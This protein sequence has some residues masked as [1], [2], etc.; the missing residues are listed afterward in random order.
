MFEVAV[1]SY[2]YLNHLEISM[3]N[4]SYKNVIKTNVKYWSGYFLC[5]TTVSSLLIGYK[6]HSKVF[7][8]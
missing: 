8:K 4:I 3:K 7:F 5:E 1:N 2:S 6:I